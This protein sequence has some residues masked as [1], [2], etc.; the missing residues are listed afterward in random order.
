MAF[1]TPIPSKAHRFA[2]EWWSMSSEG[3]LTQATVLEVTE[4]SAGKV[5]VGEFFRR[6]LDR[7]AYAAVHAEN[8]AVRTG[9]GSENGAGNGNIYWDEALRM[10]APAGC[11]AIYLEIYC[12]NLDGRHEPVAA[13]RIPVRDFLV[14]PPGGLHRL[15]YRLFD[16]GPATGNKNGIVNMTVKRLDGP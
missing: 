4:L 10:T 12:E 9:V 1:G 11:K 6:M 8:S 7:P 14:L 2:G 3:L 15:S 5:A 16:T 13:T